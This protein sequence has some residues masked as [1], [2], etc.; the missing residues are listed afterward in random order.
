MCIGCPV[1]IGTVGTTLG[2]HYRVVPHFRVEG[3]HADDCDWEGLQVDIV[4]VEPNEVLARRNLPG[5]VPVR[6]RLVEQRPHVAPDAAQFDPGRPERL[7]A[8]GHGKKRRRGPMMRW[9]ERFIE[10]PKPISPYHTGETSPSKFQDATGKH[11]RSALACFNPI[12]RATT[13]TRFV[14]MPSRS[15]DTTFL[16]PYSQLT[17]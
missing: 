9:P 13:L 14:L 5:S 3:T 16:I 1:R 15:R 6:L 12:C 11:T 8:A 4:A 7:G 17:S 10:L 2:R